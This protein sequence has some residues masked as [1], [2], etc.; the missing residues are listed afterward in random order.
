MQFAEQLVAMDMI[1]LV[2]TREELNLLDS[3][4]VKQWFSRITYRCHSSGC[5]GR[6]NFC[7]DIFPADF[8]L[9]NLRYSQMSFKRLG[10]VVFVDYYF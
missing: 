5:Q 6:W 7:N 8:L 10:K 2:A 9:E 1:L 4:A 3:E